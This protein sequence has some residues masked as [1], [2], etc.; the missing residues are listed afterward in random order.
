M[1]E[2]RPL[3]ATS[4]QVRH[5]IS[6]ELSLSIR[7]LVSWVLPVGALLAM[8][9]GLQK[10]MSQAGSAFELKIRMMPRPML[11]AFGMEHINLR[12]PVGYLATNWST[13]TLITALFASLLGA[14]LASR[15]SASQLSE[16]LYTQPIER[17]TVLVG[18]ALAGVLVLLAFNV[19]L[20][21][22]GWVTYAFAGVAISRP[23][24]FVS[25][26]A[27]TFL[28]HTTVFALSIL[29][30]V[31]AQHARSASSRALGITFGLYGLGMVARITERADKLKY[32]SPFS[33]AD[34]SDIAQT[35]GLQA[36]V[37][38]LAVA[39][40]ALL[41]AAIV[42]LNRNDMGV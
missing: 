12:D 1:R 30:A 2:A 40:V 5:V 6:L 38:V 32:L 4:A 42:R 8:T 34:A 37:A 13:I 7:S 14:T 9:L 24:A 36:R 15:E 18:K 17:H 22:V 26:F 28:V 16:T 41:I 3:L 25:V 31:S 20:S 39:T 27:G 23:G 29:A 35:G 11:A 19:T 10:S 21:L 33:Y